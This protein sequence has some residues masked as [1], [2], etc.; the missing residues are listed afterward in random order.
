[1]TAKLFCR[2]GELAGS[3]FVI[4]REATI[5][6]GPENAIV[7]E[8]KTVSREHARITL[9]ERG[10]YLLH[11]L[12]SRNGT[13][14]DNRP[15]RGVEPLGDLNVITFAEHH[16]FIFHVQ[17]GR[18]RPSEAAAPPPAP[19]REPARPP[20]PPPAPPPPVAPPAARSPV[21]PPVSV[22]ADEAS[23]KTLFEAPAGLAVPGG[24]GKPAPPAGKPKSPGGLPEQP[25]GP[26]TVFEAP[27]GLAVPGG[28][29]KPASPP[30]R[31]EAPARDANPP[32]MF[33]APAGLAVPGGIG[34]PASPPAR[35][36]APAR[37]ASPPTM[38]EA[39]AGLAV[40]SGLRSEGTPGAA[41][42][43]KDAPPATPRAAAEGAAD[44]HI[45]IQQPAPG[46][47]VSYRLTDGQHRFGRGA[48]SQ[49]RVEN[50]TLSR[51]HAILTV[52]GGLLTVADLG[53]ANGTFVDDVLITGTVE[54][55]EGMSLRFGEV[56]ATL[57]RRP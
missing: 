14:I 24:I 33:E 43:G 39:P 50:Q 30:A 16:D 25:G 42:A 31:A 13:K 7:L 52:R 23:P 44:W 51:A 36:E 8:P 27:A 5:G 47:V 35:A 40:P 29:G 15:V 46:G 55:R 45:E 34:K 11:D 41:G 4:D 6:S 37:D 32:T 28:I 18:A 54:V 20:A 26:A 2:T 53:S 56:A 12:D 49:I 22:S 1:M 57:V 10:R 48:D 38:F 17:A 3:Q 9:D 21:P 19:R